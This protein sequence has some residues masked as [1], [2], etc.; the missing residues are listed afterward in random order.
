MLSGK[1]DPHLFFQDSKNVALGCAAAELFGLLKR[2]LDLPAAWAAMVQRTTGDQTVV[3]PGGLVERID[4]DDVLLVR[5][6]PVEVTFEDLEVTTRD[7]YRCRV[8]LSVRVA[9]IPER[10]E[11]L[12][13]Q[14]EILG[15]HR[16]V[17]APR[18]AKYL[19]SALLGALAKIASE[20]DASALVENRLP[21]AV[22]SALTDALRGPCFSSGLVLE[23]APAI[24]FD[25]ATLRKVREAEQQ[26]ARR[27]A[28]HEA[29]REVRAALRRAQDEHADHLA[30][31]LTRLKDL[32]DDSPDVELPELV[33]TFSTQQ[34]GELYQALFQA[35]PATAHTQWVVAAAG[36]EVL[37]FDPKRLE[38]P[39]RRL[40]VEG[41]A[42]S[43]RSIQTVAVGGDDMVLLLGGATGVYRLPIDRAEPDLTLLVA[44]APPV[45]GGFNA[46]ALVGDRVFA[47]H[48]ELGL[49]EWCVGEPAAGRAR[50]ESMTQNTKAVRGVEFFDGALY[51]AIDDRV[52]R[53]PADDDA[54][55]P[56]HIYT[57]SMSA[58]TALCPTADGLYAGNSEGDVL[59]WV[60][61]RPTKPERLHTG[62]SRPTESIWLLLSHG[63]RRLVFTDTSLH[64]HARVL[65]DTFECRYEAGGQTLRRVE[66]APDLLV[67]TND[68][69]DRLICWAP[70]EPSTPKAT[71]GVSRLCGHSIQ[72]VCLVPNV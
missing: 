47:S 54:G 69:R 7:R 63:V 43:I 4:A 67:A 48:S 36:D 52:I 12:S 44:D 31:L 66:V 56:S 61:G 17:Q 72:D 30:S 24:R 49:R 15:S 38:E 6:T 9:V 50:F 10:S 16:V 18:I 42:G 21:E 45:R 59:H 71:I 35:E 20:H 8:E 14:R 5:T 34:R 64:L 57:G 29:A 33:R 32:A 13:F 28:E 19:Q 26:A 62:L 46:A 23:D 70:G 55:D 58:I 41:Q 60:E 39:A 22:S 2:S 68:L 37:F 65:G 25:S 40:R 1:F 53:W 3:R 11:L 27:R 51:C